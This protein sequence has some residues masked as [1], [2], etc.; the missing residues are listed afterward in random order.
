MLYLGFEI[1]PVCCFQN[2]NTYLAIR[3]GL[4]EAF[5]EERSSG[6]VAVRCT[7]LLTNGHILCSFYLCQDVE[8]LQSC[9]G[10][11]IS[12]SAEGVLCCKWVLLSHWCATSVSSSC[13]FLGSF[14]KQLQLNMWWGC[15]RLFQLQTWLPATLG[16]VWKGDKAS[17]V[18]WWDD[19]TLSRAAE[20]QVCW[21][22][23]CIRN[24]SVKLEELLS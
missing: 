24:P 14:T 16:L 19:H 23:N 4:R 5:G 3:V 10:C 17:L 18:P 9:S 7:G 6:S 1:S 8:G 12:L 21:D 22:P 15:C 20:G 11:S 2:V 13:G